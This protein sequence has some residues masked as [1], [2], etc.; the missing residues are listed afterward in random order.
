MIRE[1]HLKNIQSEGTAQ[2]KSVDSL[3][4]KSIRNA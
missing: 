1:S 2:L 4:K 3:S